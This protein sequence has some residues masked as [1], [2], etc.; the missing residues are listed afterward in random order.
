MHNIYDSRGRWKISFLIIALIIALSSIVVSNRFVSVLAD[1]ERNK[2]E[3]WAEA[4]RELSVG[5]AGDDQTLILSVIQGN[6][7]IPVIVLDDS[8]NVLWN[9]NVNLPKENQEQFLKMRA[10]KLKLAEKVI[11]I[12]LGDGSHQYLYYD[13]SVILKQLAYYPYILLFIISLFIILAYWVLNSTKRAEQNQVWVGLSK[14]T[15]HQLGTPISSLMAWIELLRTSDGVDPSLL[16]DME[17]DVQRLLTITDRFSKI[18]SHPK[19]LPSDLNMEIDQSV[20]YMRKRISNKVLLTCNYGEID[21]PVLLSS[22]LFAWVIENLI[23]NAIDAM[24]GQGCISISTHSIHSG[25]AIEIK[26]TGRGIPRYK[27]KTIFNPGYTTKKR[28]WG[29]G[30]TLVKRIVEEYHGGKIYV[31]E[32][33]L[34]T[35]TTF[36]IELRNAEG[37]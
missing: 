33:G 2:M 4:T 29:L 34:N 8:S 31:K 19:P 37:A 17:K 20:S 18:G 10:A 16:Y 24:G 9:V 12:D 13:D 21:Q 11:D 36:R 28:G 26:D 15:A 22:S 1:E 14:E 35:G 32:S 5:L 23:K 7:T 25:V 27:Y 30:L 6:K 3:I